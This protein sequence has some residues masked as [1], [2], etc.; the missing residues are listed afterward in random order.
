MSEGFYIGQELVEMIKA[1]EGFSEKPYKCTSG[2]LTIGY[3]HNLDANG[4]PESVALQLLYHDIDRAIKDCLA[5]FG[6]YFYSLNT[7]RQNVVIDMMFNLGITRFRTF[8]KFIRALTVGDYEWAARE[9]LNSKWAKQVG[10]RAQELAC[11][12]R[13]S[14]HN[15]RD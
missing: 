3:G 2:A 11:A 14:E 4:I 7:V 1:H 12:M 10:K 15:K 9:M 5:V 8:K 6:G 13:G